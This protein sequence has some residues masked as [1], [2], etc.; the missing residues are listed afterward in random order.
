MENKPKIT[1]VIVEGVSEQ[2][3]EQAIYRNTRGWRLF[4]EE[5][6]NVEYEFCNPFWGKTWDGTP[7]NLY[8][9]IASSTKIQGKNKHHI[10][11]FK[12]NGEDRFAWCSWTK[13]VYDFKTGIKYKLEPNKLARRIT[14]LIN[15]LM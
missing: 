4:F 13:E 6:S 5:P 9:I 12:Y 2:E 10:C 11:V 7:E 15:S 14:E 1:A 8:D 3:I